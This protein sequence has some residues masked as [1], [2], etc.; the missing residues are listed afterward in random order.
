MSGELGTLR[1]LLRPLQLS[2]AAATQ[3][4]FLAAYP[5]NIRRIKNTLAFLQGC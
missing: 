5:D 4:L 1:M 2:D 3:R